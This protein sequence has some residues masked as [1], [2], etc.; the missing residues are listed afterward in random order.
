MKKVFIG[1]LIIAAAAGAYYFLRKANKPETITEVNK[2][3]LVGEWKLD[4]LQFPKDSSKSQ[5]LN[6]LLL[7]DSNLTKYRYVFTKD[8]T[9]TLHPL[10]SSTVERSGYLWAK[11]DLV[12]RKDS[13]S[14]ADSL[15]VSILNKDSLV[16]QDKD[17]TILF[18]T[19]IK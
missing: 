13:S 11:N 14:T 1:L 6:I 18:F 17:S 19:K 16:L 9:M 3:L 4:S 5:N 15:T 2:E 12:I 8:S 7:I 10:D